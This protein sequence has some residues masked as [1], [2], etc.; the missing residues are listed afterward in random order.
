MNELTRYSTRVEPCV[1]TV[2]IT[3]KQS[4]QTFTFT[5][6]GST[7]LSADPDADVPDFSRRDGH[8]RT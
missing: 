4:K 8:N 1:R 3:V 5:F 2:L 7:A 6:S